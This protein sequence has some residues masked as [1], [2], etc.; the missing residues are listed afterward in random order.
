MI[1][2]IILKYKTLPTQ[3]KGSLWFMFSG[4]LTRGI[5]FLT[6]PIFT[7]ILTTQEYGQ[8]SVF[9][10]WYD[11]ASVVLT[12]NL[13]YGVYFQGLVK[14]EDKKDEFSSSL[15]GL[16]LT[17][18]IVW[19]GIYL[20]LHDRINSLMSLTTP[21]MIIMLIRCWL[22]AVM[23]FWSAQQRNEFLYKRLLIITLAVSFVRPVLGIT[24]VLTFEDK[25]TARLFTDLIV[26]AAA[27]T[28]LF[29][30]HM[31]KG[32]KF[33]SPGIWKYALT[34]AVPL[35]P[36]YLSNVILSSSDRIM[37]EKMVGE[38]E[39]GIYNLAYSISL[40]MTVLSSALLQTSE[41]WIYQK[42]NEKKIN[43]IS[44][45]A[46][47]MMIFVAG[48]NLVLIALAPEAVKIFAPPEY[49]DAI[50]VIP[51]VT[52]SVFFTFTFS[53][54]A[55]FEFYYEKK[56]FITIATCMGAGANIILNLI[57]INIFGYR[58]AGYTTLVCY[59]IY[60]IFHYI[61]MRKICR[62]NLNNADPY[63]LKK[64]LIISGT[65]LLTG[66]ILLLTY[67]LM[68]L[69]YTLCLTMLITVIINRKRITEFIKQLAGMRKNE[70]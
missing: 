50:Y 42:I 3:V 63:D 54:F 5:S 19:G 28:G 7:R 23:C 15:Q 25:V 17:M 56:H 21:L 59:I 13:F 14:F 32:R 40:V 30:E 22:R 69:R 1:K 4:V 8:I 16:T 6:V 2:K 35:L 26:E 36:H 48:A 66:F 57:F 31:K 46:F 67:D 24:A 49:T 43:D 37:I 52:M 33:F 58:A 47:P 61:F 27:Y 44:R 20:L 9:N 12:L 68:W 11:I 39:A 38:S 62:E 51:P 64:L 55:A 10:S 65:F 34:F 60:D 70:N 53:L 41:P 18:C 29:F 45:A